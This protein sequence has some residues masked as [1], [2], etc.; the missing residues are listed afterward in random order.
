M[1]YPAIPMEGRI[2]AL[3]DGSAAS[4]GCGP[5]CERALPRTGPDVCQ[6]RDRIDEISVQAVQ[7]S[8][9]YRD[10]G[11][12][13]EMIRG[14]YGTE[15]E[16]RTILPLLDCVWLSDLSGGTGDGE[17]LLAHFGFNPAQ[18]LL[19][20]FPLGASFLLDFQYLVKG[21]DQCL[22]GG[23]QR[24]YIH[25]AALAFLCGFHGGYFQGFRV[26]PEKGVGHVRH[27]LLGLGGF[28]GVA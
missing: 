8:G 1:P 20:A 24:L 13:T 3:S 19:G 15:T 23:G 10:K 5:V 26:L 12:E 11:C 14:K 7:C 21:A 27:F 25:N 9:N 4:Q 6:Q 18:L 28:R 17:E 2:G 22:V 16:F